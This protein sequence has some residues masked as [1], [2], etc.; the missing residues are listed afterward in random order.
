MTAT[1]AHAKTASFL[2]LAWRTLVRDVRAG[3]LRL[4]LVA[5]TLAVAAL[6][7]VGFFVD[8]QQRGLASGALQL[9]GGDAVVVSD[10]PTP[11]A[12]VAKARALGLETVATQA[13]ATMARADLAQGGASRLVALKSVAPGYP[14]RGRLTV[15]DA[16]GAPAQ[17]TRAIPAPGTVWV[18]AALLDALGLAL[19]D[20]LLLGDAQ[21]RIARILVLE[22]DRGAGFMDF[23]PRVLLHEADLRATG[24]VQPASRIGYRLAVAGAAPAVAAFTDWAR[25]EEKNPEV[26]GL[27]VET[28]ETG[29]PEMRQTLARAHNFMSLVAL[30]A[31]LL[32][33]VAVA[34][35]ARG[36]AARHLDAAA[37]LRVLG[38]SQRQIALAYAAEFALIGL[39]ASALGVL[40]GFVLHHA[41]LLLLA[42]LPGATPLP[43][44]GAWP[45]AFGLG[46]G[47]TL[48][49]AFGLPPVLQL[50]RVPPLRVMR[51][52]LGAPKPAT[53]SVLALGVCGFAAL[54]LAVSRDLRLG[55]IAVG[56]FAAAVA[57]FALLSWAALRLL[58]ACVH[59][60]RA[61]HWLVL[62]TRQ[63]AARPAWAVL[64]VS[65]LAVGLLALVLLGLLRTDLIRSWRQATPADA[66]NRFVIN[67][68]PDQ[69]ADFR[70]ALADAGVAGYDWYPMF[71]GRLIAVNGQ[72]VGPQSYGEQRAKNLV[73]REFNLSNTPRLP[74][75]NQIVAGRWTPGEPGAVS[76]EE[77]LANTLHLKLGDRLRFDIAGQQDEVRITS[78]RKLDWG[79]MRANFFVL[80]PLAEVANAPLTWMA[81]YR[82]PA[83]PGFDNA[84]VRR[85]ANITSVDV[86]ASIDQL[87]RVLG[88]VT[89]AVE[90]LF[91]FALA[92]GLV[93]LFAA[94]S[95][96]REE[97]AHD[98]AIMR[99]LGASERL[100]RRVQRAELAGVGLLA[101][102][103]ASS[104][105]VALA[106]ALARWVFD[107]AWSAA[108]WVPLA[109]SA[110]GAVLALAAGWWSLREVLQRPVMDSLRRCAT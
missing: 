85:F 66:P 8:R 39:L 87:Q 90:F 64:Q 40:L 46:L 18:Q 92:A 42:G 94:V 99:A 74:E 54:L 88:Q 86:G 97:R 73:E 50:A 103:L 56:G 81:A 65:S 33:A 6:S 34:L 61:P 19:G 83:R 21:L 48:L 29:R 41:L 63:I 11:A 14:L 78:L 107:F 105:A 51:R 89:G 5:V 45:A 16:P 82:A 70:Q 35:A 57:L 60:A 37:M 22:P 49:L 95:A 3:E 77:G 62:A 25:A 110:A 52:E 72:S 106:W 31:A 24:L 15:A 75:H 43:P 4:L 96:T 93:V 9:L 59:E 20:R 38:T 104:V 108:P 23:A 79:S 2:P 13:F 69:A 27:R 76:V 102:F 55:L 109:G 1:A 26:H 47:L 44:P 58:R 28:L 12:F 100:L 32:S 30:L 67:I 84:L 101:G 91:A 36:F 80:Y 98:L 71:R 7:A 68:L 17:E 10:Q 53:L